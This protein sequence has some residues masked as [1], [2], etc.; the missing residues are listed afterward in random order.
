MNWGKPNRS[1]VATAALALV[2]AL[3]FGACG[4]A[5]EPEAPEEVAAAPEFPELPGYAA[6]QI[7]P[8]N[9]MTAEKVALGKQL[10]YDTR[11]SGDGSR[12]CY[13]CHL[14]EHGLTDGRPVAI[15]AF[16]KTLTRSSPTMWNVGYHEAFYWDGRSPAL[17]KQVQ[18][19]WSSG[20]MGATGSGDAPSMAAICD[21]L[22]AIPGYAEQFQAVFGGPATPDNVAMAVAS[23]MRT[24]VSTDSA[25]VRFRNGDESALDEAAKRGWQIFSEKAKCTNCHDGLLLTDLQYHNVGIGMDTENPDIGRAAVSKDEKDTGAF[26]TPTLLDI[27]KSA[28][29]FHNGSQPDLREAVKLMSTGGIANPHLDETNLADAKNANLTDVEIDDMVAFL[30]ALDVNYNIEEPTLPQ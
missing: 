17:E 11:L 7:P 21:N 2:V 25:W 10:Y 13:S 5:P 3:A 20:N 12:S 8:E 4:A 26:K 9:P 27:S 15:G 29:Y 14:E 6:M 28:P 19:A 1:T 24:I 22:N 23:F 16:N 18:G 30:N